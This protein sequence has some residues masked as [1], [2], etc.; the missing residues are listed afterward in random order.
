VRG[1]AA[2]CNALGYVWINEVDDSV[3]VL[4]RVQ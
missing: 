1:A 4:L 3:Q 2:V